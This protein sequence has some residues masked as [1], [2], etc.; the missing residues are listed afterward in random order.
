MPRLAAPYPPHLS[1]RRIMLRLALVNQVLVIV[2]ALSMHATE[3]MDAKLT[4]VLGL[5]YYLLWMQCIGTAALVFN[6][7]G[8]LT[9]ARRGWRQMPD[10][11]TRYARLGLYK[12]LPT[13]T[14]WQMVGM[15]VICAL[16]SSWVAQQGFVWLLHAVAVPWLPQVAPPYTIALFDTVYGTIAVYVFEYLQDRTALSQLRERMAQK[17]SDQA[18]LNLLRSQL[19]PHM[20]FNTL[21][22]LYELIDESPAQA[23]TMLSHLIGFLR[24]TLAG[25]RV[26]QHAL[27]DEFKLAGDYLALMQIRMGDRLQLTLQLPPTLEGMSVPAMLLQP[28]VENAIKHGLEHRKEGGQLRVAADLH[29]QHLVLTVINSGLGERR[30]AAMYALTRRQGSG[31]GLHYVRDRLHALYGGE[32]SIDFALQPEHNLTQVTVRL[33]AQASPLN[34]LPA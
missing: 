27:A 17:L 7:L 4:Q 18:Q 1:R 10:A 30:D 6:G 24:S 34:A 20:L 2:G 15:S 25:S 33:P 3:A 21:S 26:T 8:M 22:N 19:D 14:K 16:A 29:E 9:L 32:A 13:A 31:F 11:Q 5:P 12:G 28:L 23:R